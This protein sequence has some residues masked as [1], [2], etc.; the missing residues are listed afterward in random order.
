MASLRIDHLYRETVH[1]VESVAW[2][3]DLGF[4]FQT[5]WGEEP[6]RA[7]ILFNDETRVVLAEVASSDPASSVFLATDDLESTSRRLG[8]P[9][10]DT[11]WGTRMVS[12]TDPDGRTYNFEPGDDS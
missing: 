3:E 8:S 5:T 2:W 10:V 1:W 9:V 12:A 11:H 4:V 6:H 7:G